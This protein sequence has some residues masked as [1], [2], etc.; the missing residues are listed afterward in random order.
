MLYLMHQAVAFKHYHENNKTFKEML[1]RFIKTEELSKPLLLEAFTEEGQ[2]N[3][4]LWMINN[5]VKSKVTKR[6]EIVNKMHGVNV[7]RSFKNSVGG[8]ES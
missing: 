8:G 6:K 1:P 7:V 5:V 3:E 4:A 2:E